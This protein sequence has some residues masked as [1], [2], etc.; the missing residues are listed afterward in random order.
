MRG[1][2]SIYKLQLPLPRQGP[3]GSAI[4]IVALT[5]SYFP[6]FVSSIAAYYAQLSAT[7]FKH[8]SQ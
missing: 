8:Y 4:S 7:C 6:D 5:F 3:A 1:R 2:R